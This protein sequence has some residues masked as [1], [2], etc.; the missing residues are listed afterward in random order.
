MQAWL[1][2][3][4][5][6]LVFGMLALDLGVFHRKAHA[7][8]TREALLWTLAWVAV[9]LLFNGLVYFMYEH[10]WLGIGKVVGHELSGKTAALQFLT[11]Y[12]IEKTLSL[13]N[14]FVIALVF[15]FFKVPLQYQHRVL[16][17]GI[18]GALI[19]RFVMIIIGA[20]LL[21]RFEWM[22]YVFGGLLIVAA[23]KMLVIREN[24]LDIEHNFLVR[25]ARKF[26]PIVPR[27]DGQRFFVRENGRRF[28]TPLFLALVAVEGTDVL[29]AVDSIPAIFAITR[30][31]FIVF[32][33]NVFAILGLRSLYFVLAAMLERFRHMKF[34]LVFILA[35]VGVKMLIA[36]WVHI[37]PAVSLT[38]IVVALGLGL[39]ASLVSPAGRTS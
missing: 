27:Y 9:S 7:V 36:P 4:F 32:T 6:L 25:L 10:H 8:R 17:W 5:L 23:V 39:L 22:I 35:Y 16:F 19:L 12:I 21:A 30:D 20:A 18:L 31:P 34:S 1:W 15:Q 29:F 2:I 26:L 13:D 24:S 28:A 33:S 14:I 38:V 11:G 3:G 37:T